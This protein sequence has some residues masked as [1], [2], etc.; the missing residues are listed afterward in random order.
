M[1][2]IDKCESSPP[3]EL[4]RLWQHGLHEEK[5]FHDRLNYFTAMQ[6]G[7]LGVFAILYQKEPLIGV[8]VPLIA[9]ALLFTLL[10]LII[11]VRHWRYCIHVYEQ[12]RRVVP[13]YQRTLATFAGPGR[14]DGLSI[15]RPL[16]FAVPVL[17]AGAW[18]AFFVWIIYKAASP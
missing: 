10:W 4:N 9:V 14:T 13:E 1:M 15:T 2:T 5:L 7:L 8:F 11:Q 12:I 18:I 16:A 6:V 17:F 3:D